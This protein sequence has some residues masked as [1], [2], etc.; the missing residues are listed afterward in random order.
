MATIRA[1][2]QELKAAGFTDRETIIREVIS[3]T[4]RSRGQVVREYNEVFEGRPPRKIYPARRGG[5][6]GKF[7]GGTGG[8]MAREH[9][10]QRYDIPLKITTALDKFVAEMETGKFYEESE[11]RRA[12]MVGKNEMEYWNGIT[13][14]YNYAKY[15]GFT[16]TGVRLWGTEEDIAWG[17][18][19]I[20]GFRKGI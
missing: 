1:T 16:E 17:E 8:G 12:C 6:A 20:T 7:Q 2:L 11:V 4:G 14:E 5:A 19:N 9:A 15:T 18:E 10:R 13:A 3:R